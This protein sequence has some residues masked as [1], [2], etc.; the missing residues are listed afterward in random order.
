V[1]ASEH[2]GVLVMRVWTEDGIRGLRARIIHSSDVAGGGE[3][4]AVAGSIEEI[5]AAVRA[6]LE[7]MDADEPVTSS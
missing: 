7:L 1:P 2:T 3:R 5:C 6:W 4:M